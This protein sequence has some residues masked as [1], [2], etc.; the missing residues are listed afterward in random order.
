MIIEF[1][2]KKRQHKK[3]DVLMIFRVLPLSLSPVVVFVDVS[4]LPGA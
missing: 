1:K 2:K 4:S 3:S